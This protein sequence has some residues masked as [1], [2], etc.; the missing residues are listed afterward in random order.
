MKVKIPFKQQ[1]RESML[2]GKKIM[3]SR[4]K[5]VAKPNDTFEA[6]GATFQISDVGRMTLE[7]VAYAFYDDEGCKTPQD[8]IEIWEKIHPRKGFVPSQ[9]V[10]V[11]YFRRVA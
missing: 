5:R 1:F 9:W 2:R 8:F 10:Y 11:H 3:T 4:T 7:T 6:F